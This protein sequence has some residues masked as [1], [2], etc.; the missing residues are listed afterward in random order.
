MRA[1]KCLAPVKLFPGKYGPLI[2]VLSALGV[3]VSLVRS[4]NSPR[5]LERESLVKRIFNYK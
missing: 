2:C 4:Q 3:G 5:V 1:G